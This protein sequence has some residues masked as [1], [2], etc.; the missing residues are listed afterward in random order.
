M[1]WDCM[2]ALAKCRQRF[3]ISGAAIEEAIRTIS[4]GGATSSCNLTMSM[5]ARMISP[6]RPITNRAVRNNTGF[7]PNL[8]VNAMTQLVEGDDA[9]FVSISPDHHFTVLPLDDRTIALLQGFQDTYTL[10]DWI[11]RSGKVQMSK[12][13]FLADFG[14]LFSPVQ[15]TARDAAVALFAIPGKEEEIAAYYQNGGIFV[16]AL[17]VAGIDL[18]S[19]G[20]GKARLGALA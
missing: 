13:D 4:P 17:A 10:Y 18:F 19:H 8:A 14:R 20:D 12:A 2:V 7:M 6:G 9:I 11:S 3:G 5:L 15:A 1:G 16:V